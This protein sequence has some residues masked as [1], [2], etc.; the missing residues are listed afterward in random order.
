MT[1][2]GIKY[3]KSIVGLFGLLPILMLFLALATGKVCY[4]FAPTSHQISFSHTE[5]AFHNIEADNIEVNSYINEKNSS[6]SVPNFKILFLE[7][8]EEEEAVEDSIEDDNFTGHKHTFPFE[9]N[10]CNHLY[11]QQVNL[12]IQSRSLPLYI[13]FH[14]WKYHLV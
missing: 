2:S 12:K 8:S 4:S 6:L 7:H 1:E 5:T 3:K 9:D 11:K 14:S 13:L 10:P